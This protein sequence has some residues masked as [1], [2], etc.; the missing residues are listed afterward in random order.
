VLEWTWF[1]RR[2]AG[3]TLGDR[4]LKVDHAGEHGAVNIYRGQ[5]FVSRWRAP[6]IVAGLHEFRRHEE[7]HRALFAD[8]LA[9]RAFGAVAAITRAVSAASSSA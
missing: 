5:I 1:A 2:N 9:R 4:I 6:A 3:E 8:E 7:R